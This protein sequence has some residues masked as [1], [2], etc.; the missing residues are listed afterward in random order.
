MTTPDIN[1][2]L[3]EALTSSHSE[4]VSGINNLHAEVK[5]CQEAKEKASEI[6]EQRRLA[7]EIYHEK[8]AKSNLSIIETL[9]KLTE[10]QDAKRK[11]TMAANASQPGA[12]RIYHPALHRTDEIGCR[13]PGNYG[14]ITAASCKSPEHHIRKPAEP[15]FGHKESIGTPNIPRN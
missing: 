3:K 11:A 9:H 14:W 15:Q 4:L 12:Q 7:T 5:D 2:E 10:G 1:C 6:A 8:R 13:L